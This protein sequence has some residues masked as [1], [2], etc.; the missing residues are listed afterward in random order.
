MYCLIQIKFVSNTVLRGC[1]ILGVQ[2]ITCSEAIITNGED[3]GMNPLQKATRK[4]V[5]N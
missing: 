3:V 2:W 1:G 4:T 5:E